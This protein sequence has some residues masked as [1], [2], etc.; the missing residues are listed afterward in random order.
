MMIESVETLTEIWQRSAIALIFSNCSTPRIVKY[1]S[2][3]SENGI[4]KNYN[5]YWLEG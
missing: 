3:F 2:L 4:K 1:N 5:S